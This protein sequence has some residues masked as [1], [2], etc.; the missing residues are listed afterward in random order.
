[1]QLQDGPALLTRPAGVLV[2]GILLGVHSN[3]PT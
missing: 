2:P 1:M 3:G